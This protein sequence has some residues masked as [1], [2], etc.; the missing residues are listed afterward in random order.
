MVSQQDDL[1]YVKGS[2]LS[3][4]E[5]SSVMKLGK[6][7]C[8][9]AEN[10]VFLQNQECELKRE[11]SY[12]QLSPVDFDCCLKHLMLLSHTKYKILAILGM[13]KS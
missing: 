3:N 13:T 9:I 8:A 4:Q 7:T 10:L 2:S 11:L 12:Y 5:S 6:I 1:I